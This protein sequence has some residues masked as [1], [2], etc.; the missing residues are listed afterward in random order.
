MPYVTEGNSN[1][2]RH[3]TPILHPMT[4]EL[5]KRRLHWVGR[6]RVRPHSLSSE[7]SHSG[8]QLL[9]LSREIVTCRAIARLEQAARTRGAVASLEVSTIGRDS[10]IETGT[11]SLVL[12]IA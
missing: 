3:N 6:S 5:R 1:H 9:T 7:Y 11:M 2:R 10:T 8:R 12:P 4:G